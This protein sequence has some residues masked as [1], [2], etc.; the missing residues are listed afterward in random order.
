M[1]SEPEQNLIGAL[2]RRQHRVKYVLDAPASHDQ[3]QAFDKP[4]SAHFERR[5]AQ[6]ADM[7]SANVKMFSRQVCEGFQLLWERGRQHP[8]RFT[9]LHRCAIRDGR[10]S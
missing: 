3:G 10:I 4:H 7:R 6:L 2:I 1:I 8:C 5:Q 9:R